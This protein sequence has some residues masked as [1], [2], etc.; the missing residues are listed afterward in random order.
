LYFLVDDLNEE[1]VGG[2]DQANMVKEAPVKFAS[3]EEVDS[4]IDL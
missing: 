3:I 1:V 2:E 4:V